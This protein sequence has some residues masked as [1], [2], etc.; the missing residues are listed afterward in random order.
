MRNLKSIEEKIEKV[1][2]LCQ[3][4]EEIIALYI[5]G[6]YGTYEQTPLSDIDFAVS[7]GSIPKMEEELD[8]E[9][10]NLRDL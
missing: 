7:Y 5:F 1:R 3:K 8:F 10:K 4:R 2:N 9:V 6:S